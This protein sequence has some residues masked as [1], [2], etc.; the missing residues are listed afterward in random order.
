MT[1]VNTLTYSYDG[2]G[3]VLTVDDA[4]SSYAFDYDNLYRLIES[5]NAEVV[6]PPVRA[7]NL[8]ERVGQTR[9]GEVVWNKRTQ[10]HLYVDL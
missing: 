5:D 2:V 3:N 10:G 4:F 1:T 6:R 8:D 9:G 7:G